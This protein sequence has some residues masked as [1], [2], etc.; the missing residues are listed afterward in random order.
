[1]EPDP[2]ISKGL[3]S[4]LITPAKLAYNNQNNSESSDHKSWKRKNRDDNNEYID[5]LYDQL[6]DEKKN[7]QEMKDQLNSM[8]T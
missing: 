4:H 1:M 8:Q 2:A 6:K 7:N 5:F 3:N